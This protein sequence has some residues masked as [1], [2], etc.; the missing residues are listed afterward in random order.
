MLEAVLPGI[1]GALLGNLLDRAGAPGPLS[2]RPAL[3][4]GRSP[5][6]EE[7]AELFA[8]GILERPDGGHI[9]F[10]P[11]FREVSGILLDP[12]TTITV[13]AWGSDDICGE[14][15]ALF[16]RS[17]SSGSGVIL[18][19]DGTRLELRAWLTPKDVLNLVADFFPPGPADA[20]PLPF[21]ANLHM[22][23]TATFLG[24]VDLSRGLPDVQR[25]GDE[26]RVGIPAADV[27]GYLAGRWGLVG[28]EHLIGYLPVVGG[29][30]HPPSRR[31][32][33]HA[34]HE[35]AD[36]EILKRTAAGEYYL[37]RSVEALAALTPSVIPGLQWQRA[38]LAGP[39]EILLADRLYL[40][41]DD[42]L[43][44]AFEASGPDA[45]HLS[46]PTRG[47]IVQLLSKGMTVPVVRPHQ[48]PSSTPEGSAPE[49][50]ARFCTQCGRQLKPGAGFCTGC[51]HPAKRR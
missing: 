13:R 6:P 20:R 33:E 16:P 22:A 21:E 29:A 35:L 17:I 41:G 36:A 24:L 5:S 8:A 15:N 34:L 28:F 37:S 18:N 51:G 38:T 31:E 27:H 45:I 47:E 19:Q 43:I 1:E 14:T 12:G 26:D 11:A 44:F 4:E 3:G 49:T 32:V 40:F 30:P 39:D 2:P 42:F 10:T 48:A 46:T 9:R 50:K 7:A 25:E 23:T